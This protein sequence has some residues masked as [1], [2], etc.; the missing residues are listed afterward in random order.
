[1]ETELNVIEARDLIKSSEGGKN[2]Q[3]IDVR[4]QEMFEKLSLPGFINIP[5]SEVSRK[6]SDLDGKKKTLILCKDGR[7]SYQAL[8]LL[9]AC[10]YSALVIRGGLDDW[11]EIIDPSLKA[12][13]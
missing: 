12:S 7:Q 5:L 6:I 8:K 11:K 9:E 2:L 13:S 4:S 1:M 3:L 10:G